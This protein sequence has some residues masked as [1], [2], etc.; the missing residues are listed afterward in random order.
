MKK[1]SR[2]RRHM[3][4]ID[5]SEP[6]VIEETN[7][8][9]VY[10]QRR[11]S[12]FERW[13]I[14]NKL[15]QRHVDAAKIFNYDFEMAQLSDNY[16]MVDFQKVSRV[17]ISDNYNIKTIEAKTKVNNVIKELVEIAGKILW[18]YVGL[19]KPITKSGVDSR[20]IYGSLKIVLDQLA[21]YY[22]I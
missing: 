17:M 7:K 1:L 21:N 15:K 6:I 12:V 14:E 5:P 9:G 22:R 13:K 16:S 2:T 10:R 4:K 20:E 18:D 3:L 11:L 8:A 19:E